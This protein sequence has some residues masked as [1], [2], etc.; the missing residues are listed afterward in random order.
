[1]KLDQ[2]GF[3]SEIKLEII[4]KYAGAYTSIMSKQD[5]CRGYVYIDAFAGAG[6]HISRKTGVMK[7]GRTYCTKNRKLFLGRHSTSGLKAIILLQKSLA[8]D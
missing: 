7:A 8:K 5:W 2:I 1:M 3:W 6:K 4:K